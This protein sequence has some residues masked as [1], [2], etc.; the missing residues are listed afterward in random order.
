MDIVSTISSCPNGWQ[1]YISFL[2][3]PLFFRT[4]SPFYLEDIV[5]SPIFAPTNF[6]TITKKT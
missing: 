4:F 6:K 3:I 5:F 2:L 1:K